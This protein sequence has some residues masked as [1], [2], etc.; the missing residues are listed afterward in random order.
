MASGSLGA[1]GKQRS[2]RAE[3]LPRDLQPSSCGMNLTR[4][5]SGT[6]SA[7]GSTTPSRGHR[8]SEDHRHLVELLS[9]PEDRPQKGSWL[10]LPSAA[11][12]RDRSIW[13][14][15]AAGKQR[16]Q[17]AEFPP[18]DRQP[19]T[20]APAS[21]EPVRVAGPAQDEGIAGEDHHHLVE[22]L[23]HEDHI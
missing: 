6:G 2:Q 11:C 22:L 3:L 8:A 9:L 13:L 12:R 23:P 1:A 17:R 4:A 18:R 15:G 7:W 16:T 20:T 10:W 14:P 5:C 21:L 19:S